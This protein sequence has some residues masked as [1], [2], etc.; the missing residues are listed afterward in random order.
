MPYTSINVLRSFIKLREDGTSHIY[1]VAVLPRGTVPLAQ[2]TMCTQK[3][4]GRLFVRLV[5]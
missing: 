4:C 3:F 5:M 2:T 1:S